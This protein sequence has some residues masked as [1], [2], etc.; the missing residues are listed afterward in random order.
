[1]KR[2]FTFKHSTLESHGSRADLKSTEAVSLAALPA[3]L[4]LM[5]KIANTIRAHVSEATIG[6]KIFLTVQ[7]ITTA[8]K[9][10]YQS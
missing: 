8:Q 10:S 1:V 7:F 5:S 4:K 2:H 9:V 6:L 3:D